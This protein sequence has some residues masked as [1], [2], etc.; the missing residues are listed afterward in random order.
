L[1]TKGIIQY[2]C[3]ISMLNAAIVGVGHW[4]RR[5]VDS[6]RDS[7]K[8]RFVAGVSRDPNRNQVFSHDTGVP[9]VGD[10]ANVLNDPAIDAIVLATPHS[11][12]YAQI[13][14]V[15][16]ARRHVYIEKPI[17]LTRADAEQAI[18]A[19]RAA[20][21]TLGVGF[22][23]RFAPAP[24]EFTRRINAGEIGDVLHVEGQ[25]S[26]PTGYQYQD[27][28]NHWRASRTE[29]P[30]GGMTGRGM[31]MVDTMMQIAGV[32]TSVYAF[33]ERRKL[34]ADLDDT[35]CMLLRFSNGASGYH[36]T[37]FA[38][39]NYCRVHAFGSQGWMEMI[40]DRHITHQGLDGKQTQESFPAPDKERGVLEAFADGVAAGQRF[41]VPPEHIINGIAV[42]EAIVASASSGKPIPI[43]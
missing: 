29:A 19:C 30:G 1:V 13:L 4:G 15:A 39:G 40:D 38:T 11:T 24:I 6:V 33:S 8:I 14:Q 35:T 2:H 34:T 20:G 43:A 41:T 26:G 23:R 27:M 17:T 42:L 31:H 12:H 18:A 5:L 36:A 25:S 9:L 22:N 32:V 16:K 28:N 21:I 7:T 10:I 37:I 3:R